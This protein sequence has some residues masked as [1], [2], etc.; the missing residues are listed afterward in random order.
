MTVLTVLII[1]A[2]A[3]AAAVAVLATIATVAEILPG[4]TA[5]A[6]T[7]PTHPPV[8]ARRSRA[9]VAASDQ[10]RMPARIGMKSQ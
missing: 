6:E 9:V 3:I 7:V 5:P 1:A 10:N 4:R 2:L 8:T